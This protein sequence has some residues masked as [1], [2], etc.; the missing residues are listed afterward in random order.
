MNFSTVF[1]YGPPGSGKTSVGKFLAANLDLA[2]FDLDAE[3]ERQARLTIS[4]IFT[5]EGEAGFRQ[6]EL[7]GLQRL[8]SIESGVVALGGGALVDPEVRSLVESQ[9][10]VMLL[11]APLEVLNERLRS[12]RIQRPLLI[13]DLNANLAALLEKRRDHYA[14]FPL[15]METF[16]HPPEQ[17]AREAQIKLGWY[18]VHAP[19]GIHVGPLGGYEVRVQPGCL[20]W[21]GSMLAD[22]RLGGP[23]A[24]VTDDHVGPLYA[25]RVESTLARAGFITQTIQIP[26]GEAKK[27][28]QTVA[29][30]WDSFL[31]AELERGSTVVALGG[32]VVSDLAGFAAATYLRG[33]R[34]VAVPTTLLAMADASLGGKTGFDL[35]QGKNLVG[36][37]YS[38]SLVLADPECLASLPVEELRSGMAEVVKHG[39]IVDPDL[40]A[41]C[42]QIPVPGSPEAATPAGAAAL[43]EIVRRAVAVKVQVIEADPYEQGQRAGLNF[44]HTIGHAI[45]LASGYRLRHGEAV[46]IGMVI[47]ARLAED[48]GLAS[49]GLAE[50]ITNV[51]NYLGLPVAIPAGIQ[52]NAILKAIG[53]DKKRAGGKVR[54]ALPCRIGAVQT[55][56]EIEDRKREHAIDSGFTR[57]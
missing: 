50:T 18:R 4:E 38:P 30:L 32:G 28:L 10:P 15:Q 31:F 43:A 26:S 41:L 40:F 21:I 5:A 37:F 27:N 14:S 22:R 35:P 24:I 53:V 34:W 9:G 19:Q 20:N 56:I 8:M 51:L 46:A 39:V 48:S 36:A 52:R 23:V 12:D 44:G 45:E 49:Q 11:K 6:R 3:I 47:E 57:A 17:I 25:K 16:G 42:R 1:L 13:G 7:T 54:F 55:G 2:F 33:I 29:S